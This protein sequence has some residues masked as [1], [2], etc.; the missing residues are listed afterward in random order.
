MK[1]KSTQVCAYRESRLDWKRVT[2]AA[3]G[4]LLSRR[5]KCRPQ[6]SVMAVKMEQ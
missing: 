3:E 5:R 6:G 2:H 4:S 1:K